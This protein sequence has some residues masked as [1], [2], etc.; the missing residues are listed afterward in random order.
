M[1]PL[2][3]L[4]MVVSASPDPAHCSGATTTQVN[5]CLAARFGEADAD[6]NR[7][8]DVAVQRVRKDGG[9]PVAKGFIQAQR[10]WLSYRES[11]CGAI[12]RSIGMAQSG[13]AWRPGAAYA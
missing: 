11:E 12:L 7:Y 5:A 13:R 2:L 4:T 8:Y 9:E 10:S 3:A 1:L 6:L